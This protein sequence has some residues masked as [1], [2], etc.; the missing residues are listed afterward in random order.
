MY[1]NIILV[2]NA[3]IIGI[4][5]AANFQFT[6]QN[7]LTANLANGVEFQCPLNENCFIQCTGVNS[8]TPGINF[9]I[10]GP[11]ANWALTIAVNSP[12]SATGY[13]F[14]VNIV[15]AMTA[16]CSQLNI[17]VQGDATNQF[18]SQIHTPSSGLTTFDASGNAITNGGYAI[19]GWVIF[20]GENGLGDQ[21]GQTKIIDT[22]STQGRINK[23]YIRY[24]CTTNNGWNWHDICTGS[25]MQ[26]NTNLGYLQCVIPPTLTCMSLYV[27]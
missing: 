10:K 13:T 20:Y 4:T 6:T 17:Y 7:P 23:Y 24:H 9:N 14:H 11:G 27:L 16:S 12:S 2:L 22:S 21:V 19:N 25:H 18:L 3:I 15:C 26:W 8:C 1:L 5:H